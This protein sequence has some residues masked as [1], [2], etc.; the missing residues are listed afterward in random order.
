MA[1]VSF[2][3]KRPGRMHHPRRSLSYAAGRAQAQSARAAASLVPQIITRVYPDE[4]ALRA[5]APPSLDPR[6]RGEM[7]LSLARM[8][9]RA[10]E[11]PGERN[12]IGTCT[13]VRLSLAGRHYP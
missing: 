9:M 3:I 1:R 2:R 10:E 5:A 4:C 7:S 11:Y 13:V 6:A 8:F 12:I